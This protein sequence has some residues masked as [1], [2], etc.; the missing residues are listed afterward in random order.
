VVNNP[1]EA[2]Q[3]RRGWSQTADDKCGTAKWFLIDTE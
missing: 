3:A 1:V 2:G